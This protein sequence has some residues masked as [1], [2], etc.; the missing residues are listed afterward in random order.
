MKQ[1]VAFYLDNNK[2]PIPNIWFDENTCRDYTK[3][4]DVIE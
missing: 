3:N 1:T 2:L 4:P